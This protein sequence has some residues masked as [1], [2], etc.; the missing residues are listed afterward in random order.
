MYVRL[1]CETHPLVID[2]NGLLYM[3][4]SVELI[5]EIDVSCSDG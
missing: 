3:T 4:I 1:L 2:D 5:F